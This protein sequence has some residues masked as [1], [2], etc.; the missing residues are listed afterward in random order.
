MGAP[1]TGRCQCGKIRYVLK[2][3]PIDLYACNCTACQQQSGSA[4]G[5]SM[6]VEKESFEIHGELT[7][8]VRTADSGSK[9][10][11]YFC[12]GC[13]NRIYAIS[14]YNDENIVLKPGTL[15]DT[16]WLKP[17]RMIWMRSA[18]NWVQAP[19]KMTVQ[20]TQ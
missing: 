19:K 11:T 5:L 15:D 6:V 16:S 14:P 12:P 13:G 17:S 18:Q 10:T 7:N 2:N 3:N 9:I 4:F 8:F 20:D 1:Y